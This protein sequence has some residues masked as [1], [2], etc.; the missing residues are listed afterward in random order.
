MYAI[1]KNSEILYTSDSIPTKQEYHTEEEMGVIREIEAERIALMSS[2]DLLNY[3]EPSNVK[4]A[5]IDYDEAIKYNFKGKPRLVDGKIEED[6]TE[7]ELQK[8]ELQK[9]IGELSLQKAG[10]ETLR[11]DTEAI[12]ASIDSLKNEYERIK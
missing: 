7:I 2:E 6:R 8:K 5:G 12:Q 11:E 10:L 4:V 1:I 9:Q 3:V